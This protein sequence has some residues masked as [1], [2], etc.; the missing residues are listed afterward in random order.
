MSVTAFLLAACCCLELEGV[1]L[2]GVEVAGDN[3]LWSD[4]LLYHLS[5][6]ALPRHLAE[7]VCL[8]VDAVP[9]L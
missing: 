1:E 3:H 7:K 8:P 6:H 2:E 9:V 5:L 4:P